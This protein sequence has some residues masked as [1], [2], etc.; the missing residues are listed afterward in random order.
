MPKKSNYSLHFTINYMASLYGKEQ[1]LANRIK[2]F[3][4]VIQSIPISE[5]GFNLFND[6]GQNSQLF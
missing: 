4:K 2:S 1:G 5:I 3:N 6:K